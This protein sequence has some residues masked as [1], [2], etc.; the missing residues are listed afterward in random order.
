[1]SS[2]LKRNRVLGWIGIGVIILVYAALYTINLLLPVDSINLTSRIWNWSQSALT[3]TAIA[4]ILI[5]WKQLT[6]RTVLIGL[7]L[8]IV[9]AVSH[10]Q[11]DPYIFWCGQEGL[12]V[13]FCYSAGVLL[14]K[15]RE[16]TIGAFNMPGILQLK[17][18]G[19]GIL[20]ALPLA[21]LNNLYFY[22]NSGPIQF[23]PLLVSAL[24]ALSPAIHEEI[25]FRFFILAL[26]LYLL[27]YNLP[28]KRV[29]ILAVFLSVVP[30]SFNHLPELFLQN[31]VMGLVML[32]ATSLLFG[33][34]MALLQIKKD[35]GSAIAFHWFIDFA[36]FWFGF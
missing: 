8:G 20:F 11:H 17:N 13:L 16:V 10:W 19:I 29:M 2:T 9:S 26:V 21:I 35:L 1:M 32:L 14:F 18:A 27:R 15:G 36:R 3:V 23:K 34:P 24:E 4:V 33:L 22:S 30:H 31:P 7:T 28:D 25:V 12:A 6:L 5:R